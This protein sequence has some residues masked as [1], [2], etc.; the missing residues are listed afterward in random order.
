MV[1]PLVDDR[2][3]EGRLAYARAR[4]GF[5]VADFDRTLTVLLEHGDAW[6]RACA[7]FV[8]GR[9]RDAAMLPLV[10]SNLEVVDGLVRET[11]LWARLA[12]LGG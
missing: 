3:D 11:A 7:L 8:V 1:L 12:I 9:R 10:Q 5:A 6:L 4:Y 2:G